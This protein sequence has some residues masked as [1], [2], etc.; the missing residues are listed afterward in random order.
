M[1]T[2]APQQ[3]VALFDHLVGESGSTIVV[4]SDASNLAPTPRFLQGNIMRRI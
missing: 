1:A 4:F 2:N 3:I